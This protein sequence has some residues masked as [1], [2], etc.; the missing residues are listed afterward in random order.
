MF[1]SVLIFVIVGWHD[2]AKGQFF[3]HTRV[4][5]LFIIISLLF[6]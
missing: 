5:F 3:I 4:I 1:I 2:K 6:N